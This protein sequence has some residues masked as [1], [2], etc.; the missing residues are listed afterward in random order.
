MASTYLSRATSDPQSSNTTATFSV[1][2]KRNGLSSDQS[3]WGGSYY[4]TDNMFIIKFSSDD[5]LQVY[6]K[7]G[8]SVKASLK[9]TRVLRDTNAWYHIV[10]AIDTT[11]GTAADRI[12]V[13]INGVQETSFSTNTQPSQNENLYLDSGA[14]ANY[15]IGQRGGNAEYF[16]GLM[17][18]FHYVDGTQLA[19][20]VFGETDATTGEWKINTSPSYT[21]GTKGFFV[22]KDGNSGTDQSANSNNF[23]VGG[24]TLTKTESSPSNV[25]ATL[26]AIDGL[27]SGSGGG[28]SVVYSNGNT[29]SNSRNG[30]GEYPLCRAN[31]FVNSG[32][33][34]WESKVDTAGIGIGAG[35]MSADAN[36]GDFRGGEWVYGAGFSGHSSGTTFEKYDNSGTITISNVSNSGGVIGYALD[37]DNGT[38]SIYLNGVLEGTDTTLPSN[39]SV[40]FFP[41]AL[42]TFS[43]GNSWSPIS[44]NFGNGYFGTTA[45][46]TNSGNGY[47]DADGNG[48]MN[49]SVPTNYRCL[50]TKG[51]NQ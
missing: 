30:S 17:S 44:F 4:S 20:T 45:V 22:L 49:Y 50:C 1:W 26:N 24:G 42:G 15:Y 41:V 33:W 37:L 47:Q 16:D 25:F 19:P 38:H 14:G 6:S 28:A 40:Y 21:V 51:L 11:Q 31:I 13:Y 34:Y 18:H 29:R 27:P 48:I 12:K 23:T 3:F 46:A 9:T 43:G 8:A 35:V 2:I 10:V 32:K 39:N 5:K 36:G 7:R